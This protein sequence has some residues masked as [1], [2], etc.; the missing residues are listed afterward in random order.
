[1]KFLPHKDQGYLDSRGLAFESVESSSQKAIVFRAYGLP[2]NK[3]DSAA[4]DVLVVLPPGYPDAPP[5]M[6]FTFPWLRL[7]EAGRFPTAADAPYDFAERVW[8]RWSR[9]SDVWRPGKDGIWTM[10][11]RIDHALEIAQ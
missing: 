8:Q 6:F 9:H 3:Y 10:L 11:K 5:D 2:E 1:M 7:R 4:A